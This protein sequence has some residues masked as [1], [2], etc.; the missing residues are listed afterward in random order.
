LLG[1]IFII[2]IENFITI[3]IIVNFVFIIIITISFIIVI[4]IVIAITSCIKFFIIHSSKHIIFAFI[5]SLN[6]LSFMEV[7]VIR[8][9][10]II[11]F[12]LALMG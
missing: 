9:C 8:G 1:V 11:D 6:Y 4:E 3:T 7:V 12:N 5:S 10:L 2:E